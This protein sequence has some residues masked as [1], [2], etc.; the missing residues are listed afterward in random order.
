MGG[1]APA[2]GPGQTPA[3]TSARSSAAGRTSAPP[4]SRSRRSSSRGARSGRPS[5]RRSW[6]STT[7]TSSCG[8]S[9]RPWSRTSRRRSATCWPRANWCASPKRTSR[10]RRG[11]STRRPSAQSAGTA[12]DYDVLAAQVAVENARPAVIRS[13]EPRAVRARSSCGSCWQ[14]RGEVDVEGTLGATVEA[15]PGYDEVLAQA[16]K[17]R[18]ELG[19]IDAQQGI[20]GE[21]DEDCRAPATSRASISRRPGHTK[22]R[23]ARRSPPPGTTWNAAIF[24]TVPLFDGWRTKGRVAQ[25]KSD[26]AQR[27]HRRAEAARRHLARGAD[28]RQCGAGSGGNPDRAR[29]HPVKQAERL[30]FLAEKGFELGVKTR[31]EVQDAELNLRRRA[32]TWRPRSATTGWR[33]STSTGWRATSTGARR[34][35]RRRIK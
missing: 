35:P 3:P 18:P 21:L 4:S 28:G 27:Q 11:T 30:L 26:L 8:A 9:G 17:N 5:A 23:A 31:L 29:R 6:A 7:A 14:S 1:T 34:H 13:A 12:T 19:E 22:P 32:P 15:V 20:Y 25:A 33:A 2:A 10:R 24:A 16:L